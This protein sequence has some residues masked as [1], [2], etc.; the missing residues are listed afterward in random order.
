VVL[1]YFRTAGFLVRELLRNARVARRLAQQTQLLVRELLQKPCE[2]DG[3]LLAYYGTPND[4][5]VRELKWVSWLIQPRGSVYGI[6]T[7]R[8]AF[9]GG[10]FCVRYGRRSMWRQR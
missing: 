3:V 4:Y 1:S 5:L 7:Q 2:S 6:Q 8:F 10:A 9:V